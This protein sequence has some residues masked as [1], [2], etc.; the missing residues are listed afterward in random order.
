VKVLNI[1]SGIDISII[2]IYTWRKCIH[3]CRV[4]I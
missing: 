4:W 1:V 2:I 3:A